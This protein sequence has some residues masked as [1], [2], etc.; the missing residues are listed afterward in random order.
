MNNI[1]NI[2]FLRL[3]KLYITDATGKEIDTLN[4]ENPYLYSMHGICSNKSIKDIE[5]EYSITLE[6]LKS[7]DR[8]TFIS[9]ILRVKKDLEIHDNEP[10][11]NK[12]PFVLLHWIKWISIG[13]IIFARTSSGIVYICEVISDVDIIQNKDNHIH[14]KRDVKILHKITVKDFEKKVSFTKNRIS[15]RKTLER[16]SSKLHKKELEN[17]LQS[18]LEVKNQS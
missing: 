1:N 14:P 9:S 8:N 17:F 13:D 11:K 7:M 15:G 12:C 2:W 16:V 10:S 5:N 3:D 6:K 18:F 4:C